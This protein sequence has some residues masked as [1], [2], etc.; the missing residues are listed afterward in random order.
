MLFDSKKKELFSAGN[1][2]FLAGEGS[3][4]ISGSGGI[5]DR[6]SVSLHETSERI[7]ATAGT[8]TGRQ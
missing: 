6:V 1:D 5:N 7:N 4:T 3:E 2:I 8:W